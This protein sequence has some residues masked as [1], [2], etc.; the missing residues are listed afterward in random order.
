[1]WDLFLHID[2]GHHYAYKSAHIQSMVC[3]KI[4]AAANNSVI[5][6]PWLFPWEHIILEFTRAY[7]VYKDKGRSKECIRSERR[8]RITTTDKGKDGRVVIFPVTEK[9]YKL[10][11]MLGPIPAYTTQ[12][13]LCL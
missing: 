5:H 11:P 9:E 8:R 4:T 12:T 2:L 7:N 6:L 1:M 10:A 3:I 13:P